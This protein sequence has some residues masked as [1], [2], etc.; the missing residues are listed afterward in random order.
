M[1]KLFNEKYIKNF[2]YI[3]ISGSL[4]NLEIFETN[5]LHLFLKKWINFYLLKKKTIIVPA[6]TMDKESYNNFN[7]FLKPKKMGY[8]PKFIMNNFAF[9]RSDHPLASFISLGKNSKKI[10]KNVP[11]YAYG[12]DSIFERLMNE[13]TLFLS[14]GNINENFSPIHYCETQCGVPYRYIK[15][16]EISK[17]IFSLN[18]IYKSRKII[19]DNNK[20]I[21]SNINKQV[22]KKLFAKKN[23]YYANYH[24]LIKSVCIV[25]SKRPR[26]WMKK[27]LK[28][29]DYKN[30]AKF[31]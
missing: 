20:K 21:F 25:L 27:E 10:I 17:K 13:K 7:K 2:D 5:N 30:N 18:V 8:L 16:F 14:L 12:Y 19:R 31:R 26:I 24:Q 3:F 1:K 22:I 11:S 6:F 4:I 9:E 28:Q 29:K 23:I 15:E